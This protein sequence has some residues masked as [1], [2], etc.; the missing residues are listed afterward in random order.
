[1]TTVHTHCGTLNGNLENG[2]YSYKGIP[3]A[4]S[5][6]GA[7]LWSPPTPRKRWSGLRDAR[8]YGPACMQ[9]SSS[10]FKWPLPSVRTQ[11][12]RALG[13]I[14]TIVEGD[15][16]LLLNVWTPSIDKTA[17][18]PVMVWLHGGGFTNGSADERYDAAPFASR[19]VVCVTI[20]Y[21]LGP[22][23]FLHGSGLFDG[24]LCADNRAFEDQLCA[25]RWVQENIAS[26]GGDPS[27]ITLFGQS[28]GAFAIYQLMAS[29]KAK[30]LFQRAIAMGG[31]AETCAPAKEYHQLT[32]D[33]LQDVG[34]TAGNNQAL[35]S[36]SR[37]EITKLQA[38]VSKRIFRNKN[39]E[40]Y[41]S[42][43]RNRI[44]F[45]GAA[46]GTAFL[47]SPPL[48]SY[49][50]GAHG[51]I[52]LMLGTCANDGNLFSMALPLGRTL[53][54]KIFSGNL[55]GLVPKRDMNA[56]RKYYAQQL[57]GA[58]KT[59]IIEK[60]NNDAFYR[61]PTVRAAEAHALAYPGRTW[62]Y[63]L[64]YKSALPRI[65]AIHAIDVALLFRTEQL[66][67]LLR[68]DE[69]TSR[70]SSTL[71]DALVSFAKTGKPSA[72]RMPA[73]APYEKKTRTTMIFDDECRVV[74]DF[75]GHLRRYWK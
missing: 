13:S 68:N 51:P 29:P 6:A 45:V 25:L 41:G 70:L 56:V 73:W 15:D 9:F 59:Y 36:L 46:T 48:E 33:A 23:G 5:L 26:F 2:I 24:E 50:K 65:G 71:R 54:S 28:A 58:A 10:G 69:D 16:S 63:Q 35:I 49:R 37:E 7:A 66:R 40:Q 60:I 67:A 43:S 52:D 3:Y 12:F 44:A 19:G 32:R 8:S 21:R 61:M 42:L 72:P 62:H 34:V 75:E 27:C 14:K 55:T 18:L 20:Q 38:A 57:P 30:G 1:M 47:P 22:P 39:P 53:S 31:M 4:E 74:S 11:Y 17:K 64:D